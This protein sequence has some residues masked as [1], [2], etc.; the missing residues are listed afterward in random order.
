M[1]RRNF[2]T[3]LSYSTAGMLIPVGLNSC[4]AQ[5]D[6]QTSRPK[7]LVV[8]FL[9]GAIDGLNV[10]VPH[11]DAD[12]YR[13]RPTIALPYPH[14]K[15]GVLDLDGFFGLHPELQDLM[16][17]W[18]QKSLAFVHAS[19]TQITERSHFQAQDY[20]ESGTPGVKT[21]PD[22][23]MNRLLA[24]LPQEKPTQAL[25][26]GVTT[27]LILK[28]QMK[29]AN[30]KPGKNSTARIS[31]DNPYV[32]RAF[33]SLYSGTD[34][35]SRAYQD[36]LKTR[37]IVIA[38][39]NQEMISASGGAT[40]VN[41]FVDDAAEVARLMVGNTRTQLAFMDVG[42]WD[43]HINQ[44]AMHNRL[45]PD[46]G[47]GLATLVKGLEPIYADTAIVVMSEFGRTVKENGN[48][49]TD[50]GHGN[51]MWLLGGAIRGGEIYGEWLGLKQSV[52]HQN[53]DLSVTT[54]FREVLG[55]ILQQHLSV[56]H[57]SLNRVFPDY[58]L[59][60]KIDFFA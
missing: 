54:D 51:A 13:S 7:R 11:Q 46:L 43:T 25:N 33:N 28:G 8:I 32:N 39:L 14:E 48:G 58:K 21:T 36:G 10:V 17:L 38:E 50:H 47:R 15:N 53:R 52:L 29:I 24:E 31:T 35:L 60:N 40:N 12:Y 56:S 19:G 30:L 22:G 16:P 44:K 49:G 23:W 42:G 59:T 37:E 5:T 9:R 27:P 41:A 34:D 20:M 26:V 3:A 1:K 4:V 57:N 18:Q 45:L 2:L 55:L 6:A